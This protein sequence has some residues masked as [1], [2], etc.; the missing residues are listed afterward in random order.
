VS[1]W[2]DLRRHLNVLVDGVRSFGSTGDLEIGESPRFLPDV[3]TGG[4]AAFL[5]PQKAVSLELRGD[6]PNA[7]LPDGT[8][9]HP[10][11]LLFLLEGKRPEAAAPAAA[12][13]SIDDD[14]YKVA[15]TGQAMV[16]EHA[17]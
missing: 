9:V 16:A 7:K 17:A 11:A 6:F 3:M 15:V 5:V 10:K 1:D 13:A 2:T 14:I 4:K 8:V 12:I